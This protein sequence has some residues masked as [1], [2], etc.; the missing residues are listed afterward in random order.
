[1]PPRGESPAFLPLDTAPEAQAA[2]DDAYRRMGGPERSA[3]MFRLNQLARQTAAAGIRAR[4]PEYDDQQ[5]T[6]A[7]FRLLFGDELARQVWPGE[8]LPPP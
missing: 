1:M 3:V 6:R 5:V 4:H 2:Q 7:L 8:P